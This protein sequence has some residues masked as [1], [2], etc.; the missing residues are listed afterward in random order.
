MVK[1]TSGG[2]KSKK[3]KKNITKAKFYDELDEGQLFGVIT[4]ALG[5]CHFN[6]LCSD[7]IERNGKACNKITVAKD[8]RMLINDYVIISKREFE[9]DQTKKCDILG[10]ADP[11]SDI[12]RF[13]KKDK[14]TDED[15]I[16]FEVEKLT[17]DDEVENNDDIDI[18]KI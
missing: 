6:V 14:K 18:T 4:K 15:E 16:L 17:K 3:F 13:F 2:N 9:T 10:F 7:N 12:I 5:N 11:P 8:K 1:N